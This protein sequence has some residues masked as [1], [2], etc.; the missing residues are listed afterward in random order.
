MNNQSIF[1][2]RSNQIKANKFS[3]ITSQNKIAENQIDNEFQGSQGEKKGNLFEI[4]AE[5]NKKKSENKFTFL[6]TLKDVS[7]QILSKGASG[8]VGGYG[9]ILE[10]FNLQPKEGQQ[11]PGQ[12]A[13]NAQQ[14]DVLE[15]MQKGERPTAQELLELSDDEIPNLSRL[16]TSK[17]V[18]KAIEKQTGISSGKTPAGRIAGQSAQFGGEGIVTGSGLK[19]LIGLTLSGAGGQ[20]VREAGGP[21]ALATGIEIA[22]PLA[23]SAIQGKLSPSNAKAKDIVDSGRA[24]GLTEKQIAPLMQGETKMAILSKVA[25]KGTKTKNLFASIKE[26]LGDSY[27]NIKQSVSNLGNVNYA[28]QKILIDKFTR[29]KN[30]LQKTLKASPDKEAAIK[31]IEEA[32]DKVSKSGTTAEELINFWQDINKSVKWNSIQGGKKSL[33]QLKEPILE[34]LNNVAPQAAKDFEMTNKLYTK[35]AQ[36]SKKLKPDLV[37]SFVNKGEI[38]AGAPAG[39]AL[40]YGNV[41]PL[42][43]L[44]G[45]IATRLL[46]REMLINPYFQNVANKLVKNFNQGSLKAVTESVKQVRDYMERKYPNEKWSF[47]TDN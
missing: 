12:E 34:V 10:S 33:S 3:D 19:G 35:Y 28:N 30:D 2:K 15:K 36:I 18:Q 39:L 13:K 16:P 22:G 23:T 45:E 17:E 31:F 32:V 1:H 5:K 46:S 29:I 7:E 6:E 20:A 24:I 4:Q 40:I 9:N 37:D 21:E 25:R 26:S 42:A 43:S 27:Q 41:M 8:F 14:F 11:L 47:L 44:G 38:L